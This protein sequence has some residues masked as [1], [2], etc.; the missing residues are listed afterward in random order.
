[1]AGERLCG[2]APREEKGA[3][4]RRNLLLLAVLS[5]FL[6]SDP[7]SAGSFFLRGDANGDGRVDLGDAISVLGYLFLGEEAR[8]PLDAF[9][10]NDSGQV[11]I[12]DAIY[13]LSYLFQ[14]SR[15]PAPPFPDPH[16]DPTPFDPYPGGDATTYQLL[17]LTPEEFTEVLSELVS[18]KL[19][20]GMSCIVLTLE[21]LYSDPRF[22]SGRDDPEKIKLAIHSLYQQYAIRYVMLVGDS[23]K[24]PVRYHRVWDSLYWGNRFGPADL[25][26]SDL[27]YGEIDDPWDGAR[28]GF[29]DWDAN[30][31][32]FFGETGVLDAEP[33]SWEDLNRDY[34]DLRPEVAVGRL[35][36]SDQYEL[37]VMVT[38]II[39]YENGAESP[40]TERILIVTGD[41]GHPA[42][43]TNRIAE[44]MEPLGY[45]CTLRD[46][47]VVWPEV[48]S[49][50]RPYLLNRDFETG[51][52]FV[53]HMGHGSVYSW[54]GW[55]SDFNVPPLRNQDRLPII[56]S[57]GCN[58]A[59][60]HFDEQTYETKGGGV[61]DETSCGCQDDGVF[62]KDATFRIVQQF[63]DPPR[64]LRLRAVNASNMHVTREGNSVVLK[65]GPG[66]LFS[67]ES[68]ACGNA[69]FEY[70]RSLRSYN[71]PD[72]YVRHSFFRAGI[73]AVETEMDQ[74]DSTF[75]R[76]PG[77]ADA[78]RYDLV[79][80]ESWNYP[81]YFLVE[82]NGTVFLRRRVTCSPSFDRR[83]TFRRVPGLADGSAVSFESYSNPGCYLRH[84]NFLLYVQRPTGGLFDEDATFIFSAPR[85]SPLPH[86]CSLR[87]WNTA[88][89]LSYV[90]TSA[91]R[92]DMIF[93]P[94]DGP[95]VETRATFR[96]LPSLEYGP[97][98]EYVTYEAIVPAVIDGVPRTLNFPQRYMRHFTL[99]LK[100]DERVPFQFRDLPE[101]APLQPDRRDLDGIM[102]AFLA[103][104]SGGAGAYIG[105]SAGTQPEAQ[106]FVA[107]FF[108]ELASRGGRRCILG[109]IWKGEINRFINE[110]FP[111]IERSWGTWGSGAIYSHPFKMMLFGD[112]SLRIG[113]AHP[114]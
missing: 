37:E 39:T 101:P 63:G 67:L 69:L 71:Y 100:V 109:D 77:L 17:I 104:Y 56:L 4:F 83:A 81:G 12:E 29:C 111:R 60:F 28:E 49:S 15:A 112:P 38:K 85:F 88:Q 14:G 32:G 73:S 103:L 75:R 97:D 70:W 40:W 78:T 82:E 96:V 58:T 51:Y 106:D 68:P 36:V 108:D 62:R 110:D 89:Y 16:F 13:L 8:Q 21:N 72:R 9:D 76:C 2:K 66:T 52:G 65:E 92:K 91:K 45:S 79:S 22:S 18:H 1:M 98:S 19:S 47:E 24:F 35:P 53:V 20:T 90:E 10:V 95:S 34:A 30:G 107:C 42:A 27:V 86:C 6:V 7:A 61:Y 105:S 114:H 5:C 57:A 84:F 3:F 43:T 102:E 46:H 93:A 31:N 48:P 33:D 64:T 113:G 55:Y 41:F 26:Y 11:A 59:Q 23:D 74:K 94:L 44:A 87:I 25:Y 80:F 54:V 99:R 50:Q